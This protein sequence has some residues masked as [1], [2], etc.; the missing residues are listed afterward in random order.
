VTIF[1]IVLSSSCNE[2]RDD[3]GIAI[4]LTAFAACS[5][6]RR[7]N[8]KVSSSELAPSRLPPWTETQA[9]SPAA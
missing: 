3:S 1:S 6:E 8:T 9:H 2:K 4:P 7:P 5:P